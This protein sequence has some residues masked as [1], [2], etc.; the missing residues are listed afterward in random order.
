MAAGVGDAF[1]DLH[2]DVGIQSAGGEVVEEEEG[3]GALHGDVVHAV[4]DEVGTDGLVHAHVYGDF[5]FG[6]DAVRG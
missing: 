1:D 4:V 3:R 6:A 2:G 5:K